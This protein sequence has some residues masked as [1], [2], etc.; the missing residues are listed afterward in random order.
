MKWTLDGKS[1]KRPTLFAGKKS[2]GKYQMKHSILLIALIAMC[3]LFVAANPADAQSFWDPAHLHASPGSG[4]SGVWNNITANSD[5]WVSGSTDVP[6]TPNNT[7][8]FGGSAG[9]I[10]LG[11]NVSASGLTFTVGGYELGPPSTPWV[12]TLSGTGPI[13]T[14]PAG[15]TT[16]YC[17]LAGTGGLIENGPGTLMLFGTNTYGGDTTI[18]AGILTVAGAGRLGGGNY[19]GNLTNNGVFE[20][21][22]TASQT[23]PGIISGYG[24]LIQDGP[25]TLTLG[26]VE[27]YAGDTIIN[28]GTLTLSFLGQLGGGDYP[29]N[30]Y[31]NGGTFNFSSQQNQTLSGVISGTGTLTTGPGTLT[32]SGVITYT[33][34]TTINSGTL[35]ISS[36]GQLGGGDYPGNLLINGGTFNY[37]S[38][39]NRI[40]SGTIS[41]IGA[42]TQNG[43]GILALS[44]SDTYSGNTTISSGAT[45]ALTNSGSINDTTLISIN[46]NA[47]FDVSANPTF[48]LGNQTTLNAGGTTNPA[49][50]N[51]ASGGTVSLGS[52]PVI[53]TYDGSHPALS[54]SQG[55]LLLSG[56]AFTINTVSPLGLGAYILVQQANG[57]ITSSGTFSVAGSA[58]GPDDTGSIL[59]SGGSLILAIQ[60][61]IGA[62]S[63]LVMTTEPSSTVLAG[64]TF[65][66]Q[67][68]LYVEDANGSLVGTDNSTVVTATVGTGT[69]PL[70]GTLTATAVNG[71]VTFSG[72]TAPTTAQSGLLLTFTS[73]GLASAVDNT[74]ITVNPSVTVPTVTT[75]AASNITAGSAMLNGTITPNGGTTAYWFQYGNNTSYGSFTMTNST[76]STGT[77]GIVVSNLLEGRTYHY[78]LVA[79]NSAG[80]ALGSDAS[81]STLAVSPTHFG[82]GS[83]ATL[84]SHGVA[85]PFGFTFTNTPGASFTVLATTNI[86]LPLNQ[87]SNLGTATEVSPGNYQFSDPNA[88]NSSQ[89][90][91]LQTQ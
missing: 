27:T 37:S 34:T 63:K 28:S 78:Q 39:N 84:T 12:L 77:F 5:W 9:F 14:V 21:N 46:E 73:S 60:T 59:V 11:T 33:G 66:T 61:T 71:V 85:G 25:G 23:L 69:G 91:I 76:S 64:A 58:V 75:L 36:T 81:F 31:I 35:I 89:F 17:S 82:S 18:S 42:L 13:I 29:G 74:S 20:Y 8:T 47:T 52:Q 19:S 40:L 51:G 30:L 90:Y 55:T 6:W 2:N 68:E 41:G 50:I 1:R 16:N 48:S 3:G 22:S 26:G 43:P 86:A 49:T 70:T 54:I 67:P 83:G 88:T 32:L 38:T 57:N 44:G 4:G 45:L 62:A 10:T 72:L 80:P 24:T 53:L 15:K 79:T 87:W 65:S 7:A 56:N